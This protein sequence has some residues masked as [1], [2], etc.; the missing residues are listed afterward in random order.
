LASHQN[1]SLFVFLH[2]NPLWETLNESLTGQSYLNRKELQIL[3]NTYGVDMVLAGHI[4]QDSVH[5]V[6]D[7]VYLTTTTL[8]SEIRNEDGYWGFRMIDIKKGKIGAYNYKD[9]KYSIPTYHL[10]YTLGYSGTSATALID[11]DLDFN[12]TAHIKF[13]MPRG[14]YKVDRGSITMVRTNG[15]LQEIYVISPV[16]KNH[17]LTVTLYP[18]P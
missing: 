5:I 13:I 17:E 2:H 6:N 14:E 7:T 8:G 12:I 15:D 18:E 3:V 10:N 11:N 4:H 16:E 9:P 1:Q